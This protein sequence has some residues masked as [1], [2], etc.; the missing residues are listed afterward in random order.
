MPDHSNT[1]PPFVE[2]F[3]VPETLLVL[4]QWV[5]WRSDKMPIC[6]AT[7][8]SE[9]YTDIESGRPYDEAVEAVTRWRVAGVGFV[10]QTENRIVGIDL[11]RCRNP[12]TGEIDPWAQTILDLAETY[13][14][15]SPS[16]KGL[17]LFALGDLSGATALKHD[18]AQVEM[19]TRGRYFTFTGNHIRGT[20]WEVLPAPRTLA[21][22]KARITV[23]KAARPAAGHSQGNGAFPETGSFADQ[24]SFALWAYKQSFFGRVNDYAMKETRA[25]VPVLFPSA[26]LEATG[27][28]RVRS[29]DLGRGLQEDLSIH[30]AGIKDWGVNDMGD[31]REGKR[32]P[33]DLIIEWWELEGG[34]T[35]PPGPVEAALWLCRTMGVEARELGW[36][37]PLGEGG[38]DGENSAEDVSGK[39]KT[40][41]KNRWELLREAA[42]AW[43][44]RN[45]V[46]N[47]GGHGNIARHPSGAAIFGKDAGIGPARE[48]PFITN[49]LVRGVPS[50]LQGLPG[51]GKSAIAV[52]YMNAIAC[53]KPELVGLNEIRRAGACVYVA[54]DNEKADEFK[55]RDEAFRQQH[56]LGPADYRHNIYVIDEPG[57]LVERQTGVLVPSDWI[58]RTAQMLAELREKEKLAVVVVDTLDGMSGGGKLNENAD[59]QAIM[60]TVKILAYELNCAVDLINH[61]TKG[62][63]KGDPESMDAGA[64]ARSL[65]ATA[66]FVTNAIEEHGG[67]KLVRGKGSY[68]DGPMGMDAF[69]WTEASIP[70]E[71]WEEGVLVG[72]KTSAIGVL[73]PANRGVLAKQREDAAVEAIAAKIRSGMT[74]IKAGKSGP[75]AAD[76][77]NVVLEERLTLTAMEAKALVETL[78][79]QGRLEVLENQPDKKRK[80]PVDVITVAESENQVGDSD[81]NDNDDQD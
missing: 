24:D 63:A 81:D 12:E 77:A 35:E 73:V 59:M 8:K 52:A 38:G 51:K 44:G 5:C 67:L 56:R 57:A 78:I 9:K 55:R 47:A 80:R 40:K 68:R 16:G 75:P 62:G 30:P 71:V 69:L 27:A 42:R 2:P 15:V 74:I 11:D 33:I 25:W 79:R 3:F 66:R 50:V 76:H 19:Y 17:H 72:T 60:E 31:A 32:S 10:F 13:A 45:S 70:V 64:G 29:A 48:R 53:E 36:R 58:I 54:A 1:L 14:E 6:V 18:P 28:W 21:A 22:L 41:A 34:W 4:P 46:I 20:P 7:G 39:E 61:L 26:R 65:S 43:P 23:E 37:G 49:R